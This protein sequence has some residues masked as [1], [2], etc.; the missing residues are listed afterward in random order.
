MLS[1]YGWLW[2]I[3]HLTGICDKPEGQL[4]KVIKEEALIAHPF[5]N[6][7]RNGIITQSTK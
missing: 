2:E 4:R 1:G 7:Y 5:S 3:W 6:H